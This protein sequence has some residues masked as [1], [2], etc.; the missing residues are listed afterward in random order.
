MRNLIFVPI[1]LLGLFYYQACAQ[2]RNAESIESSGIQ[3][4]TGSWEEALALA[5]AEGKLIFMDAYAKWCGPCKIMSRNV[6]TDAKAGDFFNENFINVKMDMERG[7]GP[8]LAKKYRVRAY[9]T[10]FF[11]DHTGKVVNAE[12]GY[13]KVSELIRLGKTVL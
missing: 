1:L 13:H 5:E 3:F 9:P 11:I 4:F 12:L 6:F 10:L 7:E 2:P 8:A